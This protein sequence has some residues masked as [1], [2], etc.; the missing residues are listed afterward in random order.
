MARDWSHLQTSST[1][2]ASH[3]SSIS[4]GVKSALL[5]GVQVRQLTFTYK[6]TLKA[7]LT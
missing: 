6:M 1:P 7:T 5:L 4:L 3:W 2:I